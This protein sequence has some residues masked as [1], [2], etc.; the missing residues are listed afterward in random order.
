MTS[1]T[2]GFVFT[3]SCIFGEVSDEM[4]LRKIADEPT[5]T[6]PS[7]A[8]QTC[9]IRASKE[10]RGRSAVWQ[11]Q[12]GLGSWS[13]LL[14]L[15]TYWNWGFGGF[16]ALSCAHSSAA[17]RCLFCVNPTWR[18]F[19]QTWR[20]AL[21]FWT[22][23]SITL[24]RFRTVPDIGAEI[25]FWELELQEGQ[26]TGMWLERDVARKSCGE[27]GVNRTRCRHKTDAKGQREK[28]RCH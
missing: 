27:T 17:T 28:Q 16:A 5:I 1:R 15:G 13:D 19:L 7:F 10:E 8:M 14:R 3:T 4:R 25:R 12:T 2:K 11:F 24:W 9:L 22:F 6:N 21:S 18:D 26:E 20:S 23:H